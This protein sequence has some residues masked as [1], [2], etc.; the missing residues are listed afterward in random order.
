VAFA[1]S[2][3]SR[4]AAR[5]SPS[6][7]A[8]SSCGDRLEHRTGLEV[9]QAHR[10]RAGHDEPQVV[11]DLA[12]ADRVLGR[13]E[14]FDR[15]EAEVRELPQYPVAVLGD[16]GANGVELDA[17]GVG[18]DGGA[19]LLPKPSQSLDSDRPVSGRSAVSR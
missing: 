16:L 10:V 13:L 1:E 12:E 11:G 8:K 3:F 15:A 9:E 17:Q 19:S 18:H 7:E 14:R 4:S 5:S 2:A 6:R